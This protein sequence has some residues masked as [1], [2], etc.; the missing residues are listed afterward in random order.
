MTKTFRREIGQKQTRASGAI[1]NELQVKAGR[2]AESEAGVYN[3]DES[4]VQRVSHSA[5]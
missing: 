3:N 2:E 5:S 1:L 4:V